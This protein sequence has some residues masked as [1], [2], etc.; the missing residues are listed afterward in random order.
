MTRLWLVGSI[1][2]MTEHAELP[3]HFVWQGRVH[4]I[5][6]IARR[7]RVDL[8]WW[9]LRIWRDYFRVTTDTGLLVVLY[10]DLQT[11]AWYVQRLYD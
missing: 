4:R 11:G 8:E 9:R 3:A 10:H 7:W 5:Q 1:I 2:T 6:H